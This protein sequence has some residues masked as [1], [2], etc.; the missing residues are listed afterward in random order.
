MDQP[1]QELQLAKPRRVK[2]DNQP[3]RSVVPS[4]ACAPLPPVSEPYRACPAPSRRLTACCG[5]RMLAVKV[6]ADSYRHFSGVGFAG[7]PKGG[8]QD[9][10]HS[11]ADHHVADYRDHQSHAHQSGG[12]DLLPG[13][14]REGSATDGLRRLGAR[15]GLAKPS[16][17][18]NWWPVTPRSS[19]GPSRSHPMTPVGAYSPIA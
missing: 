11:Q 5:N 13:H 10:G 4:R 1:T 19:A 12:P 18:W 15:G 2:R 8:L 14:G 3:F 7:C 16:L 17:R 6:V 9:A